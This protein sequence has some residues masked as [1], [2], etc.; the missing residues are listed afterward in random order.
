MPWDEWA[1]LREGGVAAD[2]DALRHRFTEGAFIAWQQ[3]AGGKANFGEYLK[4]LG[5]AEGS[6]RT[7]K[8]QARAALDD[9]AK[10]AAADRRQ[11]QRRHERDGQSV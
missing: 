11:Q 6:R 3:G 8:L 10:I 7:S 5:L 4:K 9:A 2:A 1:L